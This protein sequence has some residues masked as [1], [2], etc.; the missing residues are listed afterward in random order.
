[1]VSEH[2]TFIRATLMPFVE[3][4]VKRLG[5]GTYEWI[6]LTAI[7]L[8]LPGCSAVPELRSISYQKFTDFWP[9]FRSAAVAGDMA[10]VEQL[11][12]FPFELRGTLDPKPAQTYDRAGFRRLAP[13]LLNQDSGLTEKGESMKELLERTAEAPFV[14]AGRSRFG[15]FEF[16]KTRDGWRFVR[17]YLED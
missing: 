13:R 7:S 2:K 15:N 16:R 9:E 12:A 3:R 14:A 5:A 8:L 10:R 11:T 17:A 6:L 1:M 4:A